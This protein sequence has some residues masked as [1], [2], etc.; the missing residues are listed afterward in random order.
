MLTSGNPAILPAD[1]CGAWR[2]TYEHWSTQQEQLLVLYFSEHT[3][4]T[5]L[6]LWCFTLSQWPE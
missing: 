4:V 6:A 2:H 1:A 3:H 5:H